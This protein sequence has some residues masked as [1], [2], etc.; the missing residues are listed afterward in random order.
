MGGLRGHSQG[1]FHLLTELDT[2]EVHCNLGDLLAPPAKCKVPF[3]FVG[4]EWCVDVDPSKYEPHLRVES[5]DW[6]VES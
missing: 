5:C 4:Y 1:I 2:P 6:C 3:P